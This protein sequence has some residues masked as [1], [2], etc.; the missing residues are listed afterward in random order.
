MMEGF[1][2]AEALEWMQRAGFELAGLDVRV[3]GLDELAEEVREELRALESRYRMDEALGELRRRLDEILDREERAQRETSGYES[4]RMNDF[5]ER[6]HA[7]AERLSDAIERFRDWAFADPQ[8][9]EDFAELLEELERLR[10]LERF[11]AERGA[12]FRGPQA[13]DYE[14][15]QRIRERIE[16]LT[17]L[18]RD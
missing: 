18:L 7:P 6:R 12:R 10:A 14:T 2:L 16:A 17:G 1:S 5:L 8:A 15:A 4:S 9:G 3:M 11:L 13:A